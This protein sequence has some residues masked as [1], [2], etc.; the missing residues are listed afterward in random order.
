MNTVYYVKH[1]LSCQMSLRLLK[2]SL[3]YV[4]CYETF[5]GKDVV[6]FMDLQ[7]R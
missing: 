5:P 2:V 4:S 7:R 1:E 6:R 3:K